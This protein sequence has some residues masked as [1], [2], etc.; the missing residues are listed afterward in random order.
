M[1]AY[2][3]MPEAQAFK[4]DAV[5]KIVRASLGL[6]KHIQYL[7]FKDTAER[8][9]EAAT[10]GNAIKLPIPRSPSGTSSRCKSQS[11]RPSKC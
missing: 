6:P 5:K 4:V 1:Q 9:M 11:R 2:I 7:S 10:T 8:A 3:A